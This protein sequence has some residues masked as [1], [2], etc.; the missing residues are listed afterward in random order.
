[1]NRTSSLT[2]RPLRALL[3]VLAAL[4]AIATLAGCG[5]TQQQY[6]VVKDSSGKEIGRFSDQNTMDYYANLIGDTVKNADTLSDLAPRIP[7]VE[8]P[9]FSYEVHTNYQY[10]GDIV[11]TI[12]VYPTP[13]VARITN[14]PVVKQI[15][16]PLSPEAHKRLLDPNAWQ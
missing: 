2:T 4:L 8:K 3:A 11:V 10:Y 16:V 6:V 5:S 12:D 1:M 14:L 15:N 13:S 9:K 7:S